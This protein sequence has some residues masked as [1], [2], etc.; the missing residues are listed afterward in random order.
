MNIGHH[1]LEDFQVLFLS[2]PSLVASVKKSRNIVFFPGMR[3]NA[4]SGNI[5]P[6]RRSHTFTS[7]SSPSHQSVLTVA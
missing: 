5:G 7:S 3:T 2:F 6:Q 4:G 1:F